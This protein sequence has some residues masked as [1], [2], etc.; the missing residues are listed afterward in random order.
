MGKKKYKPID[1]KVADM[2]DEELN[3][4]IQLRKKIDKPEKREAYIR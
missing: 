4:I 3:A 1:V 2:S